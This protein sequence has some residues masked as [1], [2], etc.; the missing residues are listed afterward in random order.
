MT[1]SKEALDT[2]KGKI[3]LTHSALT[4]IHIRLYLPSTLKKKSPAFQRLFR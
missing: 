1:F 3:I 2:N 4:P